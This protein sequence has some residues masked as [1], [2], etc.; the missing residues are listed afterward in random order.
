MERPWKK[1]KKHSI[2][3]SISRSLFSPLFGSPCATKTRPSPS[4][5]SPFLVSK[6]KF[7]ESIASICSC[8]THGR[9]QSTGYLLIAS[10]CQRVMLRPWLCWDPSSGRRCRNCLQCIRA[11]CPRMQPPQNLY[12][13]PFTSARGCWSKFLYPGTAILREYKFYFRETFAN[14]M[15][16]FR[17][18]HVGQQHLLWRFVHRLP[19]IAK[20]HQRITDHFLVA[21]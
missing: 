5:S 11:S 13:T 18:A 17:G 20:V 2:D 9:V 15:F 14:S 21:F 16:I 8:S 12:L 3:W 10:H 7:P 1:H 4:S 19:K 6:L